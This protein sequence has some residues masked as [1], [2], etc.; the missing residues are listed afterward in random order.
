MLKLFVFLLCMGFSA[1]SYA[2]ELLAGVDA[3]RK[4]VWVEDKLLGNNEIANVDSLIDYQPT[5][6]VRTNTTDFSPS[7]NW[8][9]HYELSL[10][11]FDITTQTLANIDKQ[12][13]LGTGIHG[14]TA[15]AVPVVFYQFNKNTHN[16]AWSY[17]A[18]LGVGAGYLSL[19]GN[20]KIT[21]SSHPDFN[22]IKKVSLSDFGVAVGLYLEAA[23]G[24]HFIVIQNYSPVIED[25]HYQYQQ[26][27]ISLSYR[28]AFQL[29]DTDWFDW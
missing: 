4:S 16:D 18:G 6:G 1:Q 24:P 17:K 2:L 15:F 29:S 3:G 19:E 25:N 21:D 26:M 5:V 11:F 14:W 13:D 7:S 27:N 8:G 10:S 22:Q 28:Y 23:K 9:Y 12:E 20:F